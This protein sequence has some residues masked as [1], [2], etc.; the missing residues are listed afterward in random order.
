MLIEWSFYG[1]LKMEEEHSTL[2]N[3]SVGENDDYAKGRTG[4]VMQI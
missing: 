2:S 3:G 4:I 1:G